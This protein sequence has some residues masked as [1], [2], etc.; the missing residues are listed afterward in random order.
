MTFMQH[1]RDLYDHENKLRMVEKWRKL[2]SYSYVHGLLQIN[3]LT[4]SPMLGTAHNR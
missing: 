3:G 2:A 4:H 1:G